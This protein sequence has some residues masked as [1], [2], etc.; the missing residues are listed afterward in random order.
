MKPTEFIETIQ[1]LHE[2]AR[3]TAAKLEKKEPESINFIIW[4]NLTVALAEAHA[5]ALYL[6]QLQK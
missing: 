3:H 2:L 5:D 6:K 1:T 4:H